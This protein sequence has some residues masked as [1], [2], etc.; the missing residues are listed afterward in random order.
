MPAARNNAERADG[1]AQSRNE[2][3]ARKRIDVEYAVVDLLA[4]LREMTGDDYLERWDEP[5]V[6]PPPP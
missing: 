3:D 2:A 5:P 1:E 4:N 6:F